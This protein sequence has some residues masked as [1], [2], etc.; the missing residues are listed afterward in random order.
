LKA[1]Y[2][3]ARQRKCVGHTMSSQGSSSS[4]SFKVTKSRVSSFRVPQ[5]LEQSDIHSL[6]LGIEEG[7]K[8]VAKL[9][10]E[11][12]ELREAAKSNADLLRQLCELLK[13]KSSD[14]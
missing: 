6:F 12:Q 3:I 11:V 14:C 8:E 2:E 7:S 13:T 10:E 4:P 1:A 5:A 9:R